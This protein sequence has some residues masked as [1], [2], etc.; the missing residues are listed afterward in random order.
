MVNGSWRANTSIGLPFQ[1]NEIKV[2]SMEE[3]ASWN[4]LT[5]SSST[6]SEKTDIVFD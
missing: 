1:I 5:L 6:R 3:K 4:L 2:P